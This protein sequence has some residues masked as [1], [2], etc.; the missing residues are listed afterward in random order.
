MEK[1][2]V[3][4]ESTQLYKDY[5]EQKK[6]ETQVHKI[7]TAFMGK[8]GIETDGYIPHT[9]CLSIVV[10]K[11]SREK[12]DEQF[13]IKTECPNVFTFKM[14]SPVGRDWINTLKTENIR[15]LRKPFV[16]F[17]LNGASSGHYRLFDI[18]DKVYCSYSCNNDF[19]APEG[20]VEIK[21]SEFFK[22]VEDSEISEQGEST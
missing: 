18:N 14:T 9:N 22:I 6:N 8:W 2:W 12:L 1:Y 16:P 20:F 5:T 15:V 10:T 11:S 7:F 17:Y 19:T 21:A 4:D 13:C 3:I